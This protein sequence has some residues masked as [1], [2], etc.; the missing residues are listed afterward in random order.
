MYY[1]IWGASSTMLVGLLSST[2]RLENAKCK[3]FH[4]S[5]QNLYTFDRV[6]SCPENHQI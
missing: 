4:L 1:R 5:V 2:S 3:T 6:L